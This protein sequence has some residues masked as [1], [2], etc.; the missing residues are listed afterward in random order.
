MTPQQFIAKWQRIDL[1]ERSAYQQ[2]FLDLCELLDQPRPADIDPKGRWYTFEKGVEKTDGK[3]GLAD[4][5]MQREE[6]SGVVKAICPYRLSTPLFSM[7]RWDQTPFPP[8]GRLSNLYPAGQTGRASDC[9]KPEAGDFDPPLIGRY[10]REK[11]T[12]LGRAGKL[13]G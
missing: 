6:G 11:I 2:H 12:R 3:K 13:R 1:S 9:A 4:V 10:R 5:W 7:A 8:P